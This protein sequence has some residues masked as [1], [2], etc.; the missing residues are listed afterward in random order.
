MNH[1][2]IIFEHH[3]AIADISSFEPENGVSEYHIIIRLTDRMEAFVGQLKDIDAA[4]EEVLSHLGCEVVPVFKRYFL[5][6]PANQTYAVENSGDCCLSVIGQSPLDGTKVA[7]WIY[8]VS[9]VEIENVSKVTKVRHSGY[10]H[11]W[12]AGMAERTNE[13]LDATQSLLGKYADMLAENGCSL[14]DNCV[15]TWFFVRDVD[16]NYA[17]VV[18]G[19]NKVFDKFG[20]SPESHF[21]ASTGIGGINADSECYVTMDAYAIKG[22]AQKQ[23]AYL[24]AKD[25]MN[26]TYEYGVAF[27]RGCTIEYGDRR[28]ILISGTASIDNKGQIVHGGDVEKQAIRM[29]GNVE[30][31]LHE[32]GGTW[33]DVA[34]II[35]YLRDMAD[36]AIV[37]KMMRERFLN[38]P[39]VI[40]EAPVCRPGW[41]IEMECMAIVES[42]TVEYAPY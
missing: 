25:R 5:S 29:L 16:R 38:Y 42:S 22:L 14:F 28:H 8:A 24:Y 18:A 12:V 20:L 19:R 2:T 30:A 33:D 37:E 1:S 4:A 35:V 10:E 7:L 26:P 13:T 23:V 9:G 15:R 6:D 3:N 21:I 39:L 11:F 31:L 40:V 36:Y 34:H 32:A 27:E 41:L 17:G